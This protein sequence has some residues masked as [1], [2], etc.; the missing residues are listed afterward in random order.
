[1][2]IVSPPSSVCGRRKCV[3][4]GLSVLQLLLAQASV[5]SIFVE[6]LVCSGYFFFFFSVRLTEIRQGARSLL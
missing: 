3:R 1:M 6:D 2:M 5:Q 4:H